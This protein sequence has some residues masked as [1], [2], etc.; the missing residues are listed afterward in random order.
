MKTKIIILT[1]IALLATNANAQD[2]KP[3]IILYDN[4]TWEKVEGAENAQPKKTISEVW[5]EFQAAVKKGKKEEIMKFFKF[6]FDILVLMGREFDESSQKPG[7]CIRPLCNINPKGISKSRFEENFDVLI[8]SDIETKNSIRTNILLQQIK[9]QH[10]L[11][12][13]N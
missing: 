9:Y 11:K 2:K 7:Q 5:T 10:Y 12:I 13:V 4:G 6:P 8:D 1:L 3:A